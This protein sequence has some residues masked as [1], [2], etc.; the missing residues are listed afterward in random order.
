MHA[1]TLSLMVAG[2]AGLLVQILDAGGQ[3]GLLDDE[4]QIVLARHGFTGRIES[5]LEQRLGR[6][7]DRQL[8]DTGRLL[9]F[10]TVA[11]LNNDNN[12]SGCHAP[13]NGFGDT[14]SIA[15]GIDNNG[16][17]GPQPKRTAESTPYSDDREHRLFSE[18]DV[19]LALCGAL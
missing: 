6:R 19:E 7:I 12:C 11:G 3:R 9:F 18:S 13:T 16:I 10:D 2:V 1:I 14:Q 5:T 15:I 17:V 8:A 4:L